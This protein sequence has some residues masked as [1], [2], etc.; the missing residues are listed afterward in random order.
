MK[1]TFKL[2]KEFNRYESNIKT[3]DGYFARFIIHRLSIEDGGKNGKEWVVRE[4]NG[5]DGYNYKWYAPK[6]VWNKLSETIEVLNE[7][8][9]EGRI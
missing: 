6:T 3:E 9:K 1:I 8:Y 5:I 7:L 2:N 4:H